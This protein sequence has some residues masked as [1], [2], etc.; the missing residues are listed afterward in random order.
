MGI[1]SRSLHARFKLLCDTKDLEETFTLYTQL[2]DV[3]QAVSFA[4]LECAKQWIEAAEE[5]KYDTAVFAYQTFLRLGI[6]HLATLPSLRQRLALLKMLMASTAV[7]AFSACVRRGNFT[8]AVELLEQGRGVFW[9]QL[10]CLRSPL[11]DVIAS[12]DRGKELAEKFTR[13][14]CSLRSVL[15]TSPMLES[16]HNLACSLVTQLQDVVTDIRKSPGLSRF[17]QPPLFAYLQI[18]AASG[19]VIIVNA[20]QYGCDALI[21]LPDQDP[22]HVAFPIT[23]SRASQLSAELHSLTWRATFEDMTKEF[24]ILLREIWDEIV[25]SNREGSSG[26]L[27]LWIAYLVVPDRR[28]LP[29]SIACRWLV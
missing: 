24:L 28:V 11:D 12:G 20:S 19:P 8:S 3:S 9:S 7:D 16:H 4:A 22:I 27:S 10:I 5:C 26:L 23:K 1:L 15:D 29:S 6:H 2:T 25:F 13:L 14:T 17:L 18:V 21:V